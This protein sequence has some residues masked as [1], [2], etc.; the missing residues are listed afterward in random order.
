MLNTVQIICALLLL[1]LALYLH[2]VNT[3][4]PFTNVVRVATQCGVDMAPCEFPLRCIN[5]WCKSE[6]PSSMPLL[7]GIP[8][9]P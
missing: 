3:V 2:Y 1:I 5:G 8:V 9:L 7:T 4:E 6:H